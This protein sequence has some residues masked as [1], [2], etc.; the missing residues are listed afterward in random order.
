[1][2]KMARGM[3]GWRR[4]PTTTITTGSRESFL[5]V[6]PTNFNVQLL[7]ESICCWLRSLYG[8]ELLTCDRLESFSRRVPHTVMTVRTYAG[9]YFIPVN[10][11]SWGKHS[12]VSLSALVNYNL[13]L[14]VVSRQND[15]LVSLSQR[16][17]SSAQL[18]V[19]ERRMSTSWLPFT[20]VWGA[21]TLLVASLMLKCEIWIDRH[22]ISLGKKF[23]VPDRNWTHN[24]PNTVWAFYPV[25]YEN[26][27]R[28]MTFFLMLLELSLHVA[29][30]WASAYSLNVLACLFIGNFLSVSAYDERDLSRR[31]IFKAIVTN[32]A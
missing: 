25:S 12:R 6:F 19:M 8:I 32:K 9:D 14:L 20:V 24:L 27:W 11:W 10:L 30:P 15:L 22:D 18:V 26:A 7:R 2:V 31:Q 21:K 4:R 1:M 5:S 17:V 23:W 28:A 3:D 16:N 29:L 13:Q